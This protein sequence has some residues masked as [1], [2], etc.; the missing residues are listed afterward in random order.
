MP[1]C[2][3]VEPHRPT[4]RAFTLVELLVS[5]AVFSIL[6]I[7]LVQIASAVANT[8][9]SSNGRTERRQNGRA[10]VDFIGR[11]L[12]GAALPAGTLAIAGR[13][14]LQFVLNPNVNPGI[15]DYENPSALFWQAPLATETS[16][17]DMATIGYFVRWTGRQA[18]LCRLFV[19]PSDTA[20]N[21]QVYNSAQINNWVT[22]TV[23]DQAAPATSNTGYVGLFADNVIGFWARCF[24]S[25][26]NLISTSG[27][28]DSNTGY[29]PKDS[30]GNV[31]SPVVAP[32][33]PTSVEI[34]VVLLDSRAA[35]QVTTGMVSTIQQLVKQSASAADFMSTLPAN[36]ALRPLFSGASAHTLRVY[37]ENAP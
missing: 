25:G 1:L 9:S 6:M 3:E 20:G 17:G 13:P 15:G 8:W 35:T 10:V 7:F 36:T 19:N 2:P 29:T 28:F 14:N 31:L 34:S 12:R 24:D 18:S 30:A 26:G 16:Q 5:T 11:E 27:T 23:L 21:Y 33:L 22:K 4:K 37:L 32:A